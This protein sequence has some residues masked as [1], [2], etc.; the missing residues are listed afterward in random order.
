MQWRLDKL[1][2]A[3]AHQAHH[4]NKTQAHQ[5]RHPNTH[6]TTRRHSTGTVHAKKG[7]GVNH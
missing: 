3:Q 4:P 2:K 7:G 5:V 6:H 1:T